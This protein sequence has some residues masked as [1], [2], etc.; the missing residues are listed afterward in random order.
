MDLIE[1]DHKTFSPLILDAIEPFIH[2]MEITHCFDIQ[3]S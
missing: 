1:Q 2:E 3:R